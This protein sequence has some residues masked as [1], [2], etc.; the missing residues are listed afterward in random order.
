[1]A[2]ADSTTVFTEGTFEEQIQELVN[3]L[4]RGLGEEA[5]VS[6][7]KPFQEIIT[8]QDDGTPISEDEE[9]KRKVITLV[10][11]EV[12]TLG[13]GNDR[14]IEGFL[15]LLYAH[16]TT[17][18]KEQ[19]ELKEQLAPLIHTIVAAPDHTTVKYRMLSNLFNLLPHRSPLRLQAY[20]A[21]IDLAVSQEDI[22]VLQINQKDIQRW[23]LEWD[24]SQ[25]ERS[26]FLKR[27]CDAFRATE[28]DEKSCQYLLLYLESLPPGSTDRQTVA[29]DAVATAL[30]I[31]NLFD[32]DDLLRLE[33]I[34]S[35]QNDQLF[36]LLKIFT[37]GGLTEFQQWAPNNASILDKHSLSKEA[38]E[39]KIKLLTLASLGAQRIGSDVSYAEIAS[40]LQIPEPDV[41]TWVIDVI[42][43]NLLA[44]KLSQPN[45]TFHITR[46]TH[47]SFSDADWNNLEKRLISWK[48]ELL[49]VLDVITNAK[50]SAIIPQNNAGTKKP[51][52]DLNSDVQQI[53]T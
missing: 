9:R 16:V 38:L 14:E 28:N 48:A 46:A 39:R 30:R 25:E 50:N 34:K 21:L 31:P 19:N 47:R 43:A 8:T 1:M 53:A 17:L 6:F 4:A 26:A 37:T 49:G 18:F 44:G 36:G 3:Y 22:E 13:E 41:E 15:N 2:K 33:G 27:I 7:I 45:R 51:V 40:A 5:R 23:L 12:K 42:R 29:L 32:F 52:D 24:I 10:L 11:S 20:S 35:V